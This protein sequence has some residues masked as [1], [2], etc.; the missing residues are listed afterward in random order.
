MAHRVG[1]NTADFDHW[2]RRFC[3]GTPD[4]SGAVGLAA[5]MNFIDSLDRG[6]IQR[7]EQ[8]ITDF[9]LQRLGRIPGLRLLG[10]AEATNRIPV[11]SFDLACV[12]PEKVMSALDADGIA[13]RAGD[14]SAL[15]LLTRFG[16]D[17]AARAS[18][19]LYTTES[20]IDRLGTAIERLADSPKSAR[21]S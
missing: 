1:L 13:I 5:A 2:G 20:E 10:P 15:P 16:L 7:H 17:A 14:L 3:A 8:R 6:A 11:F 4:V 21:L 18:G 12:P 9:G 19:C